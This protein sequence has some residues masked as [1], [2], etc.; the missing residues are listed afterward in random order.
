MEE[1]IVDISDNLQQL[2]KDDIKRMKSVLA[3]LRESLESYEIYFKA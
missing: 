2:G 1:T 3:I